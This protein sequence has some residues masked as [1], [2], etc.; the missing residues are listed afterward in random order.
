MKH[1]AITLTASLVLV[2]C[3]PTLN[4][5]TVESQLQAELS[6]QQGITLKSV[7][8]PSHVAIA[9]TT[10]FTCTGNLIPAGS[11]PIVAT[12]GT[13]QGAITWEIPSSKGLLNLAQL[14]ATFQDAI[15]SETGTQL[16]IDCGGSYRVNKP[17]DRFECPVTAPT[18]ISQG[19]SKLL[20]VNVTVNVD[21]QGNVSWQQIRRQQAIARA[22]PPSATNASITAPAD[23]GNTSRQPLVAEPSQPSANT[24]PA[25]S[26]AD[27]FLN[28]PNAADG[29]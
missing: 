16:N 10:S 4:H 7:S 25:G 26:T 27:D 3:S 18:T 8:C 29:F 17:G 11:F 1:I 9:P 19:E 5:T 2:G 14:E 22:T 21:D 24:A 28:D 23:Q 6:Q 20:L 13:E 15:A 12:Q